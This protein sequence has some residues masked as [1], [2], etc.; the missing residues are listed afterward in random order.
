[1]VGKD[2]ST[3]NCP[4]NF[5]ILEGV[6]MQT[7]AGVFISRADA[8]RAVQKLRSMGL[9]DDKI[10]LLT[11]GSMEKEIAEANS[12]KTDDTE[13]P[14]M[15][16][17]LGGV[18]GGAAGI[19]GGYELGALAGALI[20]G[21]GPVVALGI[22]GATLLGLAG[23]GAG[24]VAGAA[25]EDATTTGLPEDELFVYEDALRRGR[26]VVV[27]LCEDDATA[28][29]VRELIKAGG[30]ETVDAARDKWWVGLRSA[31]KEHYVKLGMNF[32][33]EE[34]IYRQGFEAALHAKNRCKEYDQIASEMA[35]R[36]E[37][38]QHHH[39]GANAEEAYRR[40]YERGREYYQNFCDKTKK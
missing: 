21:V 11:P 16:A 4:K 38:L 15:G 18:V 12:V 24:A 36:I 8:E 6:I 31:E 9:G 3:Y 29:S 33:R 39:P 37:E 17:A 32:D 22:W 2:E 19:A 23:A 7:V 30:A 1:M 5:L 10:N 28:E 27:A 40:G 34:K 20:P 35:N 13:Q 14:G 25:L 26:S